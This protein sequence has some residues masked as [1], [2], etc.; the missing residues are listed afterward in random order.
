MDAPG[1]TPPPAYAAGGLADGYDPPAACAPGPG[2][3]TAPG[4]SVECSV[5]VVFRTRTGDGGPKKRKPSAPA[6]PNLLCGVAA[7]DA[8]A[9]LAVWDRC[10]RAV[11]EVR[12]ASADFWWYLVRTCR[13]CSS[14]FGSISVKPHC[15]R[16]RR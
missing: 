14:L 5:A 9:A 4:G 2:T 8:E 11:V 10:A 13:C 3:A 7:A 12:D 1:R 15:L 16:S 6:L